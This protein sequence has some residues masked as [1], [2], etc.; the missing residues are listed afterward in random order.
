MRPTSVLLAMALLW[1]TVP[2]AAAQGISGEA[3]IVSDY[4]YRG[5]SLSNGRP[6]LQASAEFESNAGF[7][8]GGF[9]SW[10]PHDGGSNAVELDASAGWRGTIAGALTVDGGVSWYHYPGVAD[11]DYAEAIA[12]FGW[13]RGDTGARAGIAWAPRQANL[14]DAAGDEDDNLYGFAAIERAI[15]GT[16]ISLTLEA[17]YESGAFDGAARGGK[18]DWRGGVALSRGGF[19][20]SASY[21]GAVRPRAAAGERRR[22]HGLVIALGRSF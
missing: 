22:E 7:Y 11:C 5:V 2:Q 9:G 4:R 17:G 18:L 3:E 6:A 19:T 10:A 15:P 13:E 1:T 14:I 8:L 21:V 16:P 20:A 12:T